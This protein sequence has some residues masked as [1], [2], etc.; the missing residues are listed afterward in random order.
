METRPSEL[1]VEAF[2]GQ[3]GSD[4]P[5][6]GGGSA[7]ALSGAMAAALVHMVVALTSGRA[8]A[9]EVEDDLRELG[10]AAAGFQSE[11]LHLVDID[12]AAYG[13]VIAARGLPRETDRER[14]LRRVQ[15][16]L[17]YLPD[18]EP[19]RRAGRPRAHRAPRP[20]PPPDRP[21]RAAAARHREGR[22]G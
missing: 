18:D 14:D 20:A 15:I 16:N 22:G 4:A 19:L 10:L 9:A 1:S 7:S 3:L 17:P 8:G 21:P 6:P 12:A 11:L 2:I 5:A 13:S